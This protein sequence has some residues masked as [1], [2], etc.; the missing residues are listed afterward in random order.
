MP[1][2]I[3]ANNVRLNVPQ[4]LPV[5]IANSRYSAR[6]LL[7][8]VIFSTKS[9]A[10]RCRLSGR[11]SNP[12]YIPEKYVT[13]ATDYSSDDSNEDEQP[14]ARGPF[15]SRPVVFKR[16]SVH[17]QPQLWFATPMEQLYAQPSRTLLFRCAQPGI[18]IQCKQERVCVFRCPLPDPFGQGLCM[19]TVPR[20]CPPCLVCFQPTVFATLFPRS[21]LVDLSGIELDDTPDSGWRQAY[22]RHRKAAHRCSLPVK[23]M[24]NGAAN[25]R[26]ARSP[27]ATTC[28]NVLVPAEPGRRPAH[29]LERTP[30][31]L[32][33][34]SEPDM[35]I[36]RD[37]AFRKVRR[38]VLKPPPALGGL[39]GSFHATTPAP[40]LLWEVLDTES[41]HPGVACLMSI[42]IW[43]LRAFCWSQVHWVC[44]L[45]MPSATL[46][47]EGAPINLRIR[48]FTQR[49]HATT[50]RG[51]SATQTQEQVADHI[52]AI[53]QLLAM[54]PQRPPRDE[55]GSP[56]T[57]D[58]GAFSPATSRAPFPILR[59]PYAP[60]S[61]IGRTLTGPPVGW[62]RYVTTNLGAYPGFRNRVSDFHIG[63][64]G[65]LTANSEPSCASC[66]NVEPST[67]Q[68]SHCTMCISR[69]DMFLRARSKL[70][71]VPVQP[72]SGGIG[73][74]MWNTFVGIIRSF[75]TTTATG[76][77]L[78]QAVIDERRRRREAELASHAR[79]R[80]RRGH[81]LSAVAE[82]Y[83]RRTPTE[84]A[85]MAAG[86]WNSSA[87]A[88][89]YRRTL[90]E[91]EIAAA[92]PLSGYAFLPAQWLEFARRAVG[93]APSEPSAPGPS[94]TQSPGANLEPTDQGSQLTLQ[95]IPLLDPLPEPEPSPRRPAT[96]MGADPSVVAQTEPLPE[97]EPLPISFRSSTGPFALGMNITMRLIV[98]PEI[99]RNVMT[100]RTHGPNYKWPTRNTAHRWAQALQT[101]I[102][103]I[104]HDQYTHKIS[105]RSFE[106]QVKRHR[107]N[108]IPDFS[109]FVEVHPDTQPATLVP[110]WRFGVF[111]DEYA[112]ILQ[113]IAHTAADMIMWDEIGTDPRARDPRALG[114]TSH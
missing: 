103:L 7:F 5:N 1:S 91:V 48:A 28:E 78:S 11:A 88:D 41:K 49:R 21:K 8:M 83:R 66:L 73:T 30:R 20:M 106:D 74:D 110:N 95:S 38:E 58:L 82:Q 79:R 108:N 53:R 32:S 72:L 59:N 2:A 13:E 86:R 52:T 27:P 4:L 112:S 101:G 96:S 114:R 102:L 34:C 46:E 47:G 40:G 43:G 22:T 69:R 87:V 31:D 54:V 37:V 85:F 9:V 105:A 55:R 92:A 99:P 10:W 77:P 94:N 23:L 71:H 44:P 67:E 111:E 33:P 45:Y 62:D 80:E 3:W 50:A 42:D 107:L 65:P 60:S 36:S 63:S 26:R 93:L 16:A 17:S 35:S 64:F 84:V 39:P 12:K 29:F 14:R 109:N 68:G 90:P 57:R 76:E 89:H 18:C 100:T 25:R 113:E 15:G 19:R 75:S 104:G 6:L 97:S 56:N 24:T 81:V 98:V 61:R 70:L 51:V